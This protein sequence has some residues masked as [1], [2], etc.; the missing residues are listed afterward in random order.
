MK[1]MINEKEVKIT[2]AGYVYIDGKKIAD[3]KV[4]PL[5]VGELKNALT[6]NELDYVRSCVSHKW[7]MC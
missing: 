4:N 2:R 7:V 6:P 3:I 5:N 1:K